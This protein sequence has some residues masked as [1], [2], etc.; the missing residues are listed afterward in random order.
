MTTLKGLNVA[1]YIG[2]FLRHAHVFTTFLNDTTKAAY[3]LLNE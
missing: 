1:T 2:P 3:K